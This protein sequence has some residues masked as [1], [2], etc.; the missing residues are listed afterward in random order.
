[1]SEL[2]GSRSGEDFA[3]F[4]RARLLRQA[5]STLTLGGVVLVLFGV[6]GIVI[7]VVMRDSKGDV[8]LLAVFA[9]LGAVALLI[10]RV[11]ARAARRRGVPGELS[12]RVS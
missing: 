1:M 12:G 7:T 3:A 4:L 8:G 6:V 5:I 2:K 9:V 11:L 10:A